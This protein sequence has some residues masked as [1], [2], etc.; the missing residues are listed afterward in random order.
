M[1][2]FLCQFLFLWQIPERNSLKKEGFILAHGFRGF[3]LWSAV[4]IVFGSSW[5]RTSWQQKGMVKKTAHL[6]AARKQKERRDWGQG[7]APRT[8]SQWPP[9][10]TR[11]HLLKFLPPP[12]TVPPAGNHAFNT[13][14]CGTQLIFKPW[15]VIYTCFCMKKV[16]IHQHTQLLFSLVFSL[17]L[18]NSDP[19][20]LPHD[21]ITKRCWVLTAESHRSF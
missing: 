3:S 8:C 21:S 15:H 4:T 12:Q 7:L 17:S 18:L 14:V 10:S 11:S 13:W 2:C 16:H 1:S 5:G 9:S 19:L 6:M 20:S